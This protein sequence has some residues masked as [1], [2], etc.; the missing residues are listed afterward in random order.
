MV[1]CF[2]K[3]YFDCLTETEKTEYLKNYFFFC[4][5]CYKIFNMYFIRTNDNYNENKTYFSLFKCKNHNHK[6]YDKWYL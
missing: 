3:K 4:N 2:S 6:I 1:S 5:G